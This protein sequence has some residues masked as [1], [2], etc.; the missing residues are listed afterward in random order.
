MLGPETIDVARERVSAVQT[1]WAA[2]VPRHR[3]FYVQWFAG[4]DVVGDSEQLLRVP[5]EH[6]ATF[7]S[8][9]FWA[10]SVIE[11]R[12]HPRWYVIRLIRFR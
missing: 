6:N 3:V 7:V 10:M 9:V 8:R 4:G 5:S 2:G 11:E 1:T 12:L